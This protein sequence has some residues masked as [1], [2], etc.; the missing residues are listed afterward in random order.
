[1]CLSAGE[2]KIEPRPIKH[3]SGL[4][5]AFLRSAFYTDTSINDW[6]ND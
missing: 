3:K 6:N 4:T 2:K 5:L 1:M